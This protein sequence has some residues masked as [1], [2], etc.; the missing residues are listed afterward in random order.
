MSRRTAVT[1]I[2]VTAAAVAATTFAGAGAAQ[3]TDLIFDPRLGAD[4]ASVGLTLGSEPAVI[5][6]SRLTSLDV[7]ARA[8]A[9][10]AAAEAARA[11]EE[12]AAV[13]KAK[14]WQVPVSDYNLTARFGQKGPWARGWHTGLDFAG[15]TGVAVHAAKTGKVTSAG[16]EG[17]YGNTIVID[18][19][20]GYS[21]RY[22]HLQSIGASVGQTVSGGSTIGLRGNTGNSSGPHLHFEV[23]R[24][25]EFLDPEKVFSIPTSG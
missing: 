19:G 8:Q 15:P 17:A 6:Q 22:A 7:A 24:N 18:H 10:E 25:G 9:E 11:A 16:T 2:A 23:T 21:T 4:P 12:A 3:A 14:E 5:A 1:R 20:D 13:E